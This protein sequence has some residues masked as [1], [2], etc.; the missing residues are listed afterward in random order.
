MIYNYGF[1][2]DT[3]HKPVTA[4][5]LHAGF[6]K[7][8]PESYKRVYEKFL[9]IQNMHDS[10]EAFSEYVQEYTAVFGSDD[11]GQILADL[12]DDE[13]EEEFPKQPYECVYRD[14]YIYIPVKLPEKKGKALTERTA[15]EMFSKYLP[16]GYDIDYMFVDD[17]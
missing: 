2:I 15:V 3:Y 10:E 9:Y 14:N 13:L 1:G 12:I 6:I 7:N 11:A 16:E 4:K 5:D 17:Q 8:A